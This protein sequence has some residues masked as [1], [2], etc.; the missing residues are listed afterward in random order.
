MVGWS[1]VEIGGKDFP[2]TAENAIDFLSHPKRIGVLTQAMEF[3]ASERAFS[4]RSE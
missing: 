4:P 3:L 1:A 2:F